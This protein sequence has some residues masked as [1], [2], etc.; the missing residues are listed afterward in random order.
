MGTPAYHK[1]QPSSPPPT[2]E[3]ITSVGEQEEEEAKK[4]KTKNK[5]ME[6]VGISAIPEVPVTFWKEVKDQISNRVY[7]WNPETNVTSW[8][9]PP[10][11]VIA[12]DEAEK[13]DK[14][15][16][17]EDED[18]VPLG[19]KPQAQTQAQS[20]KESAEAKQNEGEVTEAT[21]ETVVEVNGHDETNKK[22]VSNLYCSSS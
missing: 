14:I 15:R 2:V 9:L 7:Y 21:K 8:T 6:P 19:A 5:K 12:S 4:K 18:E 13:F 20:G 3:Y 17:P 16:D 10:N 11:A 22:E 1:S